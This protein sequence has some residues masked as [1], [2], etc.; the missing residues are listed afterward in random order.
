MKTFVRRMQA[1]ILLVCGLDLDMD[2]RIDEIENTGSDL[3]YYSIGGHP[4]F[5]VPEGTNKEDCFIAFPGRERIQSK[6]GES[7]CL[8]TSEAN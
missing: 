4:G 2:L 6:K 5:L 3:M 7:A 1:A 8:R